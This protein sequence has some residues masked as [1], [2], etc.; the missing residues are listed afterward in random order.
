MASVV[1]NSWKKIALQGTDV[2]F[3]GLAVT[4]TATST[5]TDYLVIDTTTGAVGHRTLSLPANLVS[6]TGSAGQVAYWDGTG[7]ITSEAGFTYNANTDTLTVSNLVVNGTTTTID[8]TNLTVEDA[9][10]IIGTGT[11]NSGSVD[12]GIIVATGTVSGSEVG[13]AFAFD[14]SAFRW[15]VQGAVSETATSIQA[16]AYQVIA[17]FG[18]VAPAANPDAAVAGGANAGYGNIHVNTTTG[19]AWLYIAELIEENNAEGGAGL[20]EP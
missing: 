5:S 14:K 4:G 15:A 19:E 16:V 1:T 17:T 3:T 2:S 11:N 18:A 10:V 12:G 9:F 13:S 6:G 7:S 20:G 8:T